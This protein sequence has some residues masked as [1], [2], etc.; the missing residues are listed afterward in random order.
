M[1]TYGGGCDRLPPSLLTHHS[2]TYNVEDDMDTEQRQR[3]SRM[4]EIEVDY[5]HQLQSKPISPDLTESINRGYTNLEYM[6][7]QATDYLKYQ[8]GDWLGDYYLH[9]MEE[10][11]WWLVSNRHNPIP[12]ETIEK[13]VQIYEADLADQYPVDYFPVTTNE[14]MEKYNAQK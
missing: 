14:L 8:E 3:M 4:W 12:N 6:L 10:F 5:L 13:W 11:V 1:V 9:S 7:G 2:N